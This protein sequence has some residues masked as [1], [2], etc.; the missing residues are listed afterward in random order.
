MKT[1]DLFATIILLCVGISPVLGAPALQPIDVQVTTGS[2]ELA[3]ASRLT[4][5][6]YLLHE[7]G[8]FNEALPLAR[9]ALEIREKHLGR[10]NQLVGQSL[11]N[12]ARLY[13][14]MRQYA[15]AAKFYQRTLSVYVKVFGPED[16]RAADILVSLAW[17]SY[18][19][20]DTGKAK[21][22]LQRAL[23]IREKTLGPESDEVGT[24]LYL[25]GQFHQKLGDASKAVEF[26]E[27][28]IQIKEKS[29]AQD[30]LALR[31]LLE[32]CW[33]ALTQLG[34]RSEAQA[35][36]E[37][38]FKL[39]VAQQLRPNLVL[40]GSAVFRAE[41]HYP[42]AARKE[43]ISGTVIVEVTVN[44]TGNV[45]TTR[46]ICGPDLLVPAAVEAARQWRFA[47]TTLDGVPIKV[48][49]TITFNFH[50]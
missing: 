26:Y 19:Y 6:V 25:I 38:T 49:G 12:L 4:D 39:M 32:K 48:I 46:A 29:S 37:R 14:A 16:T 40:Q 21:S 17:A 42:P 1:R 10:E 50:L 31:E 23:E 7:E 34:K 5:Q 44:E 24:T 15:E 20:G 28:A 22:S 43:R 11:M 2:P 35:I 36:R 45:I 9:R 3:E 33:C 30:P 18:G 13:F 47:P 8:K 27:R 41:P